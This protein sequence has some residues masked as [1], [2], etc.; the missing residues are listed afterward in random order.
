MQHVLLSQPAVLLL[1][2]AFVV[3]LQEARQCRLL[4]CS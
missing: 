3:L 2:L 1:L 4:I